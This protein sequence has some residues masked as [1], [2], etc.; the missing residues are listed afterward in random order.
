MSVATHNAETFSAGDTIQLA[1]TGG[2]YSAHYYRPI[3]RMRVGNVITY[4]EYP[5]DTPV[6]LG[7]IDLITATYKWTASGSGT[8]EYYLETA[9]GGDPGISQPDLLIRDATN[10][11]CDAEVTNALGS[12]ADHEWEWGDNDTLGYSTVYFRDDS[13]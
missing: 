9:A 8:N 3:G 4:E 6:L 13:R 12:L 5:G 2:D 7:S 10:S 1:D 11:L